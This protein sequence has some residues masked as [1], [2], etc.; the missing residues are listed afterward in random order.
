M[1][2]SLLWLPRVLEEAG[3]KVAP[4]DGWETRGRREMG[5]VLGII[6]HLTACPATGNMPALGTLINGRPDLPGPLAQLGL[7]RDGTYYIVA[8]GL[9][10]HA[11]GGSWQGITTGNSNF[12]GIEAENTGA[13]SDV[14]PAVQIDAYQR[15]CAAILR[16]IG[17]GAEFCCGHKEYA[18][19]KGRKQDPDFDMNVFRGAV[20]DLLEV[21]VT[22]PK[23]IPA[24]EHGP[25][26][27]PTL[28]RGMQQELVKNIQRKLNVEQTGLFGPKTEAAVREIQR[29][30][31]I[32]P[33]GIVGPKTWAAIDAVN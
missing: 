9:C 19:P 18:L 12:I 2:Y 6:C 17:R 15:G 7:G 11:G 32:V 4:V 16:H 33:D 3:L 27:R 26:G 10:N 1:T 30:N 5:A 21:H 20:S 8:A 23:V 31:G 29:K 25:N 14:W 28:R 24:A 22:T 13:K